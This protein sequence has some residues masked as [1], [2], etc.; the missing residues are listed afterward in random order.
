[1]ST[2][3]AADSINGDDLIGDNYCKSVDPDIHHEEEDDDDDFD[4]FTDF[5]EAIPLVNDE[6]KTTTRT[7]PSSDNQLGSPIDNSSNCQSNI[8]GNLI[9]SPKFS[10]S[11]TINELAKSLP[12]LNNIINQSFTK[13]IEDNHIEAEHSITA[14]LFED[15]TSQRFV[16][17]INS[18]LIVIV[19]RL[20]IILIQFYRN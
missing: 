11:F 3:C 14:D 15:K 9:S 20:I 8:S 7:R 6:T 4:D 17:N 13:A 12:T 5:Q 16:M 18:N 19:I 2:N 10:D 1:M